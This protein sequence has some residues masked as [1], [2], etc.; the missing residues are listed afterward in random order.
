VFAKWQEIWALD[1][2]R[3]YTA[4]F[5]VYGANSQNLEAAEVEIFIAIR[6]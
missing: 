3:A 1:I 4:D 5:E 6:D 2:P